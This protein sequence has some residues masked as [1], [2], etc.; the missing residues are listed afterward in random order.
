[1][2]EKLNF[3]EKNL[4]K[5]K[6]VYNSNEL[7]ISNVNFEVNASNK[8]DIICNESKINIRKP[9]KFKAF[10]FSSPYMFNNKTIGTNRLED[11]LELDPK[12][13]ICSASPGMIKLE[14][15]H[16]R[17]FSEIEIC[18]YGG[19]KHFWLPSL[20]A[21]S[22]IETSQD[23]LNWT[24]VGII[25]INYGTDLMK[26]ELKESIAKYIKFKNHTTIGISFLKVL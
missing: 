1:M 20:G 5:N 11:L 2:N 8:I 22:I 16:L 3:I 25:P 9:A 12:T 26:I 18:S 13:G 15:D 14:F 6:I 21:E 19:D 7:K 24:K 10:K 23:N 4:I 17:K